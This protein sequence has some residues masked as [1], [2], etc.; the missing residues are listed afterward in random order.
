M[1]SNID[2][3]AILSAA[4]SAGLSALFLSREF[5]WFFIAVVSFFFL[6]GALFVGL[7]GFQLYGFWYWGGNGELATPAVLT[8][9]GVLLLLIGFGIVVVRR[10][11]WAIQTD[12]RVKYQDFAIG[13]LGESDEEF[14]KAKRFREEAAEHEFNRNL[15]YRFVATRLELH[16]SLLFKHAEWKIEPGVNVLLGRNGF[17]KS[18]LLRLLVGCLQREDEM[19]RTL[20]RS[21]PLASITIDLLRN[22]N[23]V[24]IL[25]SAERFVETVG[26]VPLLAIPDSRFMDRT[27]LEVSPVHEE[28]A[29]LRTD[30]AHHFLH[31]KPYGDVIQGLLYEICLDYWQHGRDFD[32]PVFEFLRRAVCGLTGEESFDFHSIERRGRTGFQIEVLTEGNLEPLPIQYASQGTLSVLAMFGLIRSYLRS[33]AND[34]TD[35]V[36]ETQPAI[37]VIDEADAHLHPAWQQR[38][39]TLLR[40]LFP[41]VQFILT[42]HSPLFVAGCWRNEVAILRKHPESHDIGGFFVEQLDEDFVGASAKDLYRKIFDIEELDHTYLKYKTKASLPE[43]HKDRINDLSKM[44]EKRTLDEAEA[45]ELRRLLEESRRV[46]R[47]NE[48]TLERRQKE[49]EKLRVIEL[50]DRLQ[51]LEGRLDGRE[52]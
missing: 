44:Q 13:K 12:V 50:E 41:N 18:L 15:D 28:S 1:S 8:A 24:K 14:E 38:V 5:R 35:D 17:G 45:S 7:G 31:Q 49:R 11:V 10:Y 21:S 32:L 43:P 27:S 6:V 47:A 25:R 52:A 48:V 34:P 30:G 39:P 51:E 23:E 40:E 16:E 29:D 4:P 46:M 3:E 42:A 9:L 2:S 37:V 36:V 26:K 33:V 22:G 19:T 20:L